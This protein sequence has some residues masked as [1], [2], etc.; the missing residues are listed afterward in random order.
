MSS[1]V[2][3]DELF[4]NI[5]EDDAAQ[6]IS[7]LRRAADLAGNLWTT[8]PDSPTLDVLAQKVGDAARIESNRIP[9]G[10]SGLLEFFCSITSTHGTRASLIVQCLRIIGNTCAYEGE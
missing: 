4:D 9:L 1:P 5:P 8:E 2:T 10:E 7:A 6:K 3:I